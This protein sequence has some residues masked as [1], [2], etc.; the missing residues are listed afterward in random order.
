ML[1]LE[2]FCGTKSVSN[3]AESIGFDTITLDFNPK[4]KADYVMDILD[5]DEKWLDEFVEKHGKPTIIHSSVDCR[6]YS[7]VRYNWK[8]LGHPPPDLEYADSLVRKTRFIIDYLKPQ[9]WF[10]ENPYTGRLKT[11]GLLDDVPFKRCCYC[12]Y[13]EDGTFLTKKETAVWGSVEAWKPKMCIKSE[14]YC[15]NKE[16]YGKHLMSIGNN[17]NVNVGRTARLKIPRLLI[18]DLFDS[19]GVGTSHTA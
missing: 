19:I 2:L 8:S 14:G 3:Y 17:K 11:R 16:Q 9:H 4:F 1:L 13:D 7:K 12:K 15:R 18:K 10:I 6:H 5:V